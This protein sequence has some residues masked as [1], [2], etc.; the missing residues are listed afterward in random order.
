MP[1]GSIRHNKETQCMYDNKRREAADREVIGYLLAEDFSPQDYCDAKSI[2]FC[3][4]QP[5]GWKVHKHHTNGVAVQQIQRQ[6]FDYPCKLY[7]SQVSAPRCKEQDK[8]SHYKPVQL[9]LTR[10]MW[11]Q[12]KWPTQCVLNVPHFPWMAITPT[13]PRINSEI[14]GPIAYLVA[15]M[16]HTGHSF[17]LGTGYN[18]HFLNFHKQKAIKHRIWKKH[19]KCEMSWG[20][21]QYECCVQKAKESHV[22]RKNVQFYKNNCEKINLIFKDPSARSH[23]RALLPHE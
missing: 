6:I 15:M 1:E 19:G 20:Q 10:V 9:E 18:L 7:R 12:M 3:L 14:V 4:C 8:H 11:V 13:S 16:W 23:M 22:G 2:I 5:G 17:S 21:I